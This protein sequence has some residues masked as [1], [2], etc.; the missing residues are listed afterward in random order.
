M[1]I[2]PD[3]LTRWHNEAS[4]LGPFCLG[5]D[6]SSALLAKW[7]IPD[8]AAGLS[9]FCSLVGG[10]TENRVAMVKPQIAFF[11]RFGSS[12]IS[13]LENFVSTMQSRGTLVLMDAKRGDIGSTVDAYA[14]AYLDNAS[15]LR[16]D[17]MTASPYLGLGALTPLFVKAHD[18]GSAVF[19]VVASSNPEGIELQKSLHPSGRELSEH[20]AEEIG[21]WNSQNDS[22][23]VGAVIGATR[24]AEVTALLQLIGNAPILLPGFG[25]QG[26]SFSMLRDLPGPHRLIPTASRSVLS[27]G[28]TKD[29]FLLALDHHVEQAAAA[30]F[31]KALQ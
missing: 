10:W 27:A 13:T 28:P 30:I 14:G 17:G 12:G 11:E 6:P 19:V 20:I 22:G 4:R 24:S 3:F 23:A 8:T 7:G 29:A 31:V 16:S 15:L 18:I 2:A 9:Q 26:A 1:R 5:I 25:A 21:I